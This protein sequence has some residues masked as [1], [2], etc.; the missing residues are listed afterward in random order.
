MLLKF[1]VYLN[2]AY[3]EVHYDNCKMMVSKSQKFVGNDLL[4]AIM[5]FV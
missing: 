5:F 2:Y 4:Y 3:D 1:D